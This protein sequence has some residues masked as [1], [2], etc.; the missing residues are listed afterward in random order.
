MPSSSAT[1]S[2]TTVSTIASRSAR[3]S[4]RCSIGRRKSTSR[5]GVAPV[6]RTSDE[7]GTVPESQSSGSCGVSSTAYS[8]SPSRSCQRASMS[9]T[10]PSARSSK[11]SPAG[12]QLRAARVARRDGGAPHPAAAPVA[13]RVARRSCESRRVVHAASLIGPRSGRRVPSAAVSPVRRCSRTACGRPAVTTLTY[14]YADQTAVLGPLATYAEPHAYDL[15]ERAQRAA[16]AR[17]A[18]GRCCG[19]RPDPAAR[20]SSD[21]LLALADAV[22][23]AARP[24]AADRAR[25]RAAPATARAARRPARSPARCSPPTDADARPTRDPV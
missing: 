2:T 7:S 11:R 22:R 12:R 9:V 4:Q 15:C 20:P 14:V 10:M 1:C 6:P 17:R 5:V 24:V 19:W 23:E 25:R 21:D 8:T 18:A 16:L 13:A 3:V